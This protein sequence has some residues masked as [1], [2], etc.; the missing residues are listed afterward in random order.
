MDAPP[1]AAPAAN[2]D[3]DDNDDSGEQRR[4]R[5]AGPSSSDSDAPT[6][7]SSTRATERTQRRVVDDHAPSALA[8]AL[9]SLRKMLFGSREHHFVSRY[10]VASNT[11]LQMTLYFNIPY[12]LLWACMNQLLFSWKSAM[13]DLPI[14][15]AVVSPMV[16][17]VF[18]FV[19]PLRIMLGYVGN[20]R[21]R[22]A[23]LGGFW[24]L[25]LLTTVVH[26]YFIVFQ[27]GIGWFNLPIEVVMSVMY[28][29]LVFTQ[30]LLSYST[31][32]RLIAKVRAREARGKHPQRI[33]SASS[34]HAPSLAL[35]VPHRRWRISI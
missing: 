13:F 32:K 2:E 25:T 16:F 15:V 17:W 24:V 12:A 6:R 11:P 19:E 4:S 8:H 9:A 21:E 34:P 1:T 33:L 3:D 27:W 14:V 18:F 30:M 31:I 29:L 23:W 10:Q 20:L 5:R 22:V 35:G 7:R 26:I 28:L